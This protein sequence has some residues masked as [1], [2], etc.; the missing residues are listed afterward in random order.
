VFDVQTNV[1]SLIA[2]ASA[3]LATARAANRSYVIKLFEERLM[4]LPA[5]QATGG[6]FDILTVRNRRMR[7]SAITLRDVF[8]VLLESNLRYPE[9]H[10]LFCRSR[11]PI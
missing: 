6:P 8:A 11:W 5:V 2:A 9:I 3:E 1:G 7:F 4:M 10:C